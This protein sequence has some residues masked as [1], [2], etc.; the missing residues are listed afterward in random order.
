LSERRDWS[1]V[2]VEEFERYMKAAE[3]L[4][5]FARRE[6]IHPFAAAIAGVAL[7][8]NALETMGGRV[9]WWVDFVRT[10]NLP[11]PTSRQPSQNPPKA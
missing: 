11:P 3:Q 9:E 1:F 2:T 5:H 6:R 10:G 4:I 8:R 7:I